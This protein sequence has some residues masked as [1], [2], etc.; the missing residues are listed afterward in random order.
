MSCA[1]TLPL[2]FPRHK[3]PS[4]V[5]PLQSLTSRPLARRWLP[6]FQKSLR[7]PITWFWGVPDIRGPQGLLGVE[8]A[9][10]LPDRD[11]GGRSTPWRSLI[12]QRKHSHPPPIPQPRPRVVAPPLCAAVPLL[13]RPASSPARLGC[14][15]RQ[16][17]RVRIA[18]LRVQCAEPILDPHLKNLYSVWIP[19][20]SKAS[21]APPAQ[22]LPPR[23]SHI[24]FRLCGRVVQGHAS[25][26]L[27]ATPLH[28]SFLLLPTSE[29]Q[30]PSSGFLHPSTH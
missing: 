2:L 1:P 12:F 16:G 19:R 22:A 26:S 20:P 8:R 25:L 24:P 5:R 27:E 17:V 13:P 21:S 11:W 29:C 15:V 10:P 28:S 4:L 7:L 23:F 14:G 30:L 3:C 9:P 6:S 18:M